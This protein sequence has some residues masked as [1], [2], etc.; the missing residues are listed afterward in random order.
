MSPTKTYEHRVRPLQGELG[1][2]CAGEL[3]AGLAQLAWLEVTAQ[4]VKEA[5][6]RLTSC[7]RDDATGLA[8]KRR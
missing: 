5:S 7:K 4:S 1:G 6:N 2:T 8:E 3:I